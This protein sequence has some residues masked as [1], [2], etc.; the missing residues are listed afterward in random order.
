M[1]D[2]ISTQVFMVVMFQCISF[3]YFSILLGIISDRIKKIHD[4]ITKGKD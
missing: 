1:E 4:R 3:I 2:K